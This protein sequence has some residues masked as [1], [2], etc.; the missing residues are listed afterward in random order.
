LVD[1]IIIFQTVD[2]IFFGSK[3]VNRLGEIAKQMGDP[4]HALVKT[5][6]IPYRLP[7]GTTITVTLPRVTSFNLVANPSK[8]ANIGDAMEVVL[9][10]L[11]ETELTEKSVDCIKEIINRVGLL[12]KPSDLGIPKIE[13]MFARWTTQLA[14]FLLRV[15]PRTPGEA[16]LVEKLTRAY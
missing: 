5:I 1:Q 6:Q 4:S 10:G 16:D 11:S 13:K 2:S 14:P 12:Q 9:G 3:A 8:Y 15:N 7:H